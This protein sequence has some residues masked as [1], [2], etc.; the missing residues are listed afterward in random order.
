MN[1]RTFLNPIGAALAVV[2]DYRQAIGEALERGGLSSEQ[3]SRV[4]SDVKLGAAPGGSDFDRGVWFTLRRSHQA[5][6]GFTALAAELGLSSAVRE[7]FGGLPPL[8]GHQ[9]R[10]IRSILSGRSTVIATGTGSG[11]TEAFLIPVLE[12]CFRN[13]GQGV[14]AILIYPMNALVEDQTQR[15]REY[16]KAT[17]LRV[18][19]FVGEDHK[20]RRQERDR[21][22]SDPPDIL[23]TNHVMLERILTLSSRQALRGRGTLRAIV[24]DEVHTFRGNA[25]SDVAW[26]LR[27]LK[28]NAGTNPVCIGASATLQQHGGCVPDPGL[29][30]FL[31]ELF[32]LRLGEYTELIAPSYVEEPTEGGEFPEPDWSRL[33]RLNWSDDLETVEQVEAAL[34]GEPPRSP[35]D[36]LLAAL[37]LMDLNQGAELSDLPERLRDHALVRAWRRALIDGGALAYSEMV[38]VGQQLYRQRFGRDCPDGE[39][40]ARAC[41]AAV[42]HANWLEAEAARAGGGRR[43]RVLDL[44]V[45]GVLRNVNGLVRLCLPCECYHVGAEEH[46]S[47][48]GRVLLD[49]WKEDVAWA[50]ALVDMEARALQPLPAGTRSIQQPL[51]R[52]ARVDALCE[53]P[54]DGERIRLR[55]EET[56]TEGLCYAPD[57]NGHYVILPLKT[58]RGTRSAELTVSPIETRHSLDYLALLARRLLR[59][60]KGGARLLV[61]GDAREQVSAAGYVL[62]EDAATRHLCWLARRGRATA[63]VPLPAALAAARDR[64]SRGE[65]PFHE[66]LHAS[67]PHWF[68][69]LCAT[70]VRRFPEHEGLIVLNPEHTGL[71]HRIPGWERLAT[72]MGLARRAPEDPA[73]LLVWIC[74]REGAI[75]WT[76]YV[77]QP[78]H[79][80]RDLFEFDHLT[81]TRRRVVTFESGTGCLSG[82]EAVALTGHANSLYAGHVNRFADAVLLSAMQDLVRDGVMVEIADAFAGSQLGYALSAA[83]VALSSEPP[84]DHDVGHPYGVPHQTGRHEGSPVYHPA[85]IHSSETDREKRRF[86][87]KEFREPSSCLSQLVATSTL[88]MGVDIGGLRQVLCHG[89]PPSPANYAQRAGRAGRSPSSWYATVFTW[90]DDRRPHDMFHF[91]RAEELRRLLSGHVEPPW[92]DASNSLVV[93]RHLFA[94]AVQDRVEDLDALRCLT[95]DPL[96]IVTTL[97][98]DLREGFGAVLGEEMERALTGA[99]VQGV[100][101]LIGSGSWSAN[102][103]FESPLSPNYGF[104]RDEVELRLPKMD[105]GPAAPLESF[106]AI[107]VSRRPPEQAVQTWFPGRVVPTARGLMLIEAGIAAGERGEGVALCLSDDGPVPPRYTAFRVRREEG[108]YGRRT[109]RPAYHIETRLV[110]TERQQGTDEQDW[111]SWRPLRGVLLRIVNHGPTTGESISVDGV[112]EPQTPWAFDAE[113]DALM[114]QYDALLLGKESFASLACAITHA[115]QEHFRLSDGDLQLLPS[116]KCSCVNEPYAI[117]VLADSG[118]HGLVCMERLAAKL[119]DIL[120][121]KAEQLRSCD[122]VDGCFRCL[123]TRTAGSL[124]ADAKRRTAL[125]VLRAWLGEIPLSPELPRLPACIRI[126]ADPVEITVQQRG[127]WYCW[128]R[129]GSALLRGQVRAEGVRTKPALCKAFLQATEGIPP[130]TCIR[131]RAEKRLR[132]TLRGT[133]SRA[134]WDVDDDLI[135]FR[136]LR[137]Q[138][139]EEDD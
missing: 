139:I 63:P 106:Q 117:F 116:V 8:H 43:H 85:E 15:I 13:P 93:R 134:T 107:V 136:G 19:S 5:G 70:S 6:C 47:R 130:D 69:R 102:S 68:A 133:K 75:D 1:S 72:T 38:K 28:A 100:R 105:L 48:C 86:I 126:V 65:S 114:V 44:V 50:A 118:Q 14:K 17:S 23:V 57:V 87:E 52:V 127:N 30:M 109:R 95:G 22:L 51:V 138:I 129:S 90:C 33:E 20:E 60:E 103:W 135:W 123:R 45:H 11:K 78:S 7:A 110:G 96:Q 26:L 37:K 46:C 55:E 81:H 125:A 73:E 122:C 83:S 132:D 112:A 79:E 77:P 74:L 92:L 24:L 131:I 32:S 91:Q 49:C 128:T 3:T 56:A 108:A 111:L 99:F 58:P 61:F 64:V 119:P 67:I 25:G 39:A 97:V 115:V 54:Q 113:C 53:L 101:S 84:S 35:A 21:L 66:Q 34:L 2:Q 4:L 40:L 31:R 98:P 36:P 137:F 42:N 29:E 16:A 41:L 12:L 89:V 10:A 124:V 121:A 88:E 104:R 59:Y 80:T 71:R 9:E 94:V 62:K 120:S 18:A 27:R 76:P 82:V